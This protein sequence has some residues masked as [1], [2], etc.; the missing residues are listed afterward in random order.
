MAFVKAIMGGVAISSVAIAEPGTLGW[1]VA[2]VTVGA[3]N[4]SV[5]QLHSH[6]GII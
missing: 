1:P 6:Y 4:V 5:A 3:Q 2:L